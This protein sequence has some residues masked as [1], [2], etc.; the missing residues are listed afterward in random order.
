MT[1]LLMAHLSVRRKN[2]EDQTRFRNNLFAIFG[3]LVLVL[4]GISVPPGGFSRQIQ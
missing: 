3:S 2:A 4:V 1:I